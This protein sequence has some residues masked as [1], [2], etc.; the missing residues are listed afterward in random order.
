MTIPQI[1]WEGERCNVAV[2]LEAVCEC[3][4]VLKSVVV[5]DTRNMLFSFEYGLNL[6]WY[7]FIDE[8]TAH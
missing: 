8:T 3:E 6:D 1:P 2:R 7:A 4:G 5:G